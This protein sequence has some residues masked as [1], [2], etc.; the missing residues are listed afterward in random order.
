VRRLVSKFG[1]HPARL[2]ANRSKK[3]GLN[4]TCIT[5]RSRV[6][7][8]RHRNHTNIQDPPRWPLDEPG[9]PRLAFP[10]AK[11][12]LKILG[13]GTKGGVSPGK[14]ILCGGRG[15]RSGISFSSDSLL[16][17][18]RGS[19][20]SKGQGYPVGR[21]TS[22]SITNAPVCHPAAATAR[23]NLSLRPCSPW[24]NLTSVGTS[25]DPRPS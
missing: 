15:T 21:L 24:S 7:I 5:S 22:R 14:R 1:S 16:P 12:I 13:K 2:W 18:L 17:G 9:P 10:P 25:T 8:S 23:Q 6:I 4:T 20:L 11:P 19:Q 3:L